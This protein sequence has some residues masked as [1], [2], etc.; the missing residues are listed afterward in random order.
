MS[1]VSKLTVTS[2]DGT[3]SL[4]GYLSESSN[5]KS[6]ADGLTSPFTSIDL[7]GLQGATWNGLLEL[8]RQLKSARGRPQGKISIAQINF[9]IFRFYKMLQGFQDNYEVESAELMVFKTENGEVLQSFAVVTSKELNLEGDS[10]DRFVST[11][12]GYQILGRANYHKSIITDDV[13]AEERS[14]IKACDLVH[15]YSL[16]CESIFGM[17][18]DLCSG[19]VTSIKVIHEELKRA[20]TATQK[21]CSLNLVPGSEE[22]G[23]SL[24][25]DDKTS[26]STIDS[27]I[28][29]QAKNINK[30]LE[31]IRKKLLNI[32]SEA[33][34][35]LIA[36]V[37]SRPQT[38]EMLQ[39]LTQSVELSQEAT[40][41]AEDLG[42]TAGTLMN[43]FSTVQVG[44]K[45]I[46]SLNYTKISDESILKFLEIYSIIDVMAEE[47]DGLIS[48]LDEYYDDTDKEL[49]RLQTVTQCCDMVKQMMDHRI[50]EAKIITGYLNGFGEDIIDAG[51]I[52]MMRQ[53]LFDT[54]LKKLVTDQEKLAA[55]FFLVNVRKEEVADDARPG[56]MLLF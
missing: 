33:Q 23:S 42:E 22:D 7:K 9:N 54:I 55:D 19:L 26:E 16:F 45:I 20:R 21:V 18:E 31:F 44:R 46:E 36:H 40:F 10:A 47:Q 43:H 50:N 12:D 11:V 4:A 32:A 39:R 5:F 25:F 14:Y 1:I 8:D 24:N 2:K 34:S 52:D 17:A 41:L 27:R 53:E 30:K 3:V 28:E 38:F 56:D 29:E 51:N 15:D 48:N 35:A 37:D 13:S 6:L 49:S